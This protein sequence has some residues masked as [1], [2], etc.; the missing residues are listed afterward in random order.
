MS[1]DA[2]A[3]YEAI[4]ARGVLGAEVAFILGTGLGNMADAVEN[5]IAIPYTDLP[6]FP[7]LTVS[8]HDGQL[9]FGTQE[10]VS[11]VYMQGRAHYY[12]KG[13]PNCME[14]PLETLALLG[15]QIVVLTA[16][17]GSLNADFYPGNLI[18]ITDHINLNGVNPLIGAGGDGGIISLVDAYD[19]RLARRF[20]RATLTAGV[21]IR[22]GVYMWFSGPSF[23]TPAEVK[24]ARLLGADVVGMSVV[25]EVILARRIGLR[26]AAVGIVSNFGAGFQGGNPSHVETRQTAAQ[27]AIT[28]KRLLRSFLRIKESES[29]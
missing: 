3:A 10:G 25:P 16:A 7:H 28:L 24:M 26:T 23:E 14:T 9:I 11:V 1:N 22:E 4:L 20:K 21:N 15:A 2:E 12:E 29:Q 18:L 6:G 13:I 17:V 27:G 5:P 19:Q 8:G